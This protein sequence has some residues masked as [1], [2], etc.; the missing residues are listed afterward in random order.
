VDNV[1]VRK[2]PPGNRVSRFAISGFLSLLVI[3]LLAFTLL[4]PI[5]VQNNPVKDTLEITAA[6]E[7]NDQS[8]GKEVR[9]LSINA[10]GKLLPLESVVGGVWRMDGDMLAAYNVEAPATISFPDVTAYDI[11]LTVVKQN[12][13]GYMDVSFGDV[14]ERFDFYSDFWLEDTI[15]ISPTIVKSVRIDLLLM[16][17]GL[18]W[19]ICVIVTSKARLK[20]DKP[21]AVHTSADINGT[22]EGNKVY[23]GK[24]SVPLCRR[25]I[26]T[27]IKMCALL[28]GS[29]VLGT[30]LLYMSFSLPLNAIDA[31][32][33]ESAAT[34]E[35]EGTYPDLFT[36]CSSR[37]DN[38]SDA[39]MFLNA[40]YDGEESTLNKAM[41][42]Y[43]KSGTGDPVQSLLEYCSGKE[44][45]RI[46]PYA[47]YWHG[48]LI[49]LKPLLSLMNYQELRLFNHYLQIG[50]VFIL[51]W[52]LKREKYGKYILPTVFMLGFWPFVIA[53]LSLVNS[54]VFYIFAVGSCVLVWKYKDWK[55]SDNMMLFFMSLGILTSFFDL[56]SY[57]LVSFGIPICLYFCMEDHIDLYRSVK[58]FILYGMSWGI[59]YAGMWA[60]K[61]VVGSLLT[62]Q[63]IVGEALGTARYRMSSTGFDGNTVGKLETILLNVKEFIK[64]PLIILVVLFCLYLLFI[65]LKNKQI[66]CAKYNIIFIVIACLPFAW[67]FVVTNHSWVHYAILTFRELLISV[68]A[69]MCFF[70]KTAE[71][72]NDENIGVRIPESAVKKEK[73]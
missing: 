39:V 51:L 48:Y 64:N 17:W 15:K 42:I 9:I 11:E 1:H 69:I 34:F 63:D 67:Y 20:Y 50:V 35:H 62:G 26:S 12:G 61:W 57:P 4:R 3:I 7:K 54:H 13:S 23:T 58:E 49:Y 36:W 65:A 43:S 33:R 53:G 41:S 24:P 52:L 2:T 71:N 73:K 31:H 59:G 38:F 14:S 66:K 70:V 28:L 56:L 25:V 60:G 19:A 44:D 55:Y 27:V 29:I 45:Y 37:L 6:G 46:L 30:M 5:L 18:L 47:R 22:R 10:D 40:V 21:L 68:F 8:W 16:S 32:V 72:V